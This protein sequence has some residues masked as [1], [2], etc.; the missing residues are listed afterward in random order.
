[1]CYGLQND[2]LSERGWGRS[3][4]HLLGSIAGGRYDFKKEKLSPLIG[5]P[6]IK[7][8]STARLRR[9]GGKRKSQKELF[10]EKIFKKNCGVS[11]RS[12]VLRSGQ[13]QNLGD[14]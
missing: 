8:S 6:T 12:G 3:K 2:A 13:L 4:K 5:G 7:E 1:V 14:L 10:L 11:N 9:Q